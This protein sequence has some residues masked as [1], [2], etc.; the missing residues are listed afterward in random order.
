MYTKFEMIKCIMNSNL[1]EDMKEAIGN[2]IIGEPPFCIPWN[3]IY[4]T[5]TSDKYNGTANPTYNGIRCG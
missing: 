3:I 4:N 1:E 5:G 2:Y